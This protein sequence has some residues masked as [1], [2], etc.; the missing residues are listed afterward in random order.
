MKE[1]WEI[2]EAS[3]WSH[4]QTSVCS[5]NDTKHKSKHNQTVDDD[6]FYTPT[7]QNLHETFWIV[8]MTKFF[9]L[10]PVSSTPEE[11]GQ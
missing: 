11:L 5:E 9:L 1:A 3:P 7:P 2:N 8:T 4:F 10:H 6:I